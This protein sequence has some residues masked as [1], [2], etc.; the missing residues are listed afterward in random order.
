M[1]METEEIIQ[2]NATWGIDFNTGWVYHRNAEGGWSK[3]HR[4]TVS[5]TEEL[6]GAHQTSRTA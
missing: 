4:L 3:H 1:V 5:H 2:I 6:A